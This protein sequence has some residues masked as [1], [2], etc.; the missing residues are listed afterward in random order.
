VEN[1]LASVAAPFNYNQNEYDTELYGYAPDNKRIWKRKPDGTEE[2]YFYGI[3]GQKLVTITPL[4]A[5]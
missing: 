3:S 5:S 2:P 4:V 1:R